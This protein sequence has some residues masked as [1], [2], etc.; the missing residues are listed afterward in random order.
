MAGIDDII[1]TFEKLAEAGEGVIAVPP[2]NEDD[3]KEI[4]R[5]M[6][7]YLRKQQNSDKFS[8][9]PK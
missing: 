4:D 7:E 3:R 5:Q 6:K 8:S 2:K 9:H 1:D